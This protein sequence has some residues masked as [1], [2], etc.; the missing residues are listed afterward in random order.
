MDISISYAGESG[1]LGASFISYSQIHFHTFVLLLFLSFSGDRAEGEKGKSWGT[2]RRDRDG[3]AW[4]LDWFR[5]RSRLID[6]LNSSQFVWPFVVHSDNRRTVHLPL[7]RL[8][9]LISHSL[10]KLWDGCCLT[11]FYWHFHIHNFRIF[12]EDGPRGVN[13]DEMRPGLLT[14][15][16]NVPSTTNQ[17]KSHYS[18]HRK[19]WVEFTRLAGSGFSISISSPSLMRFRRNVFRRVSLRKSK[20]SS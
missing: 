15:L 14:K 7:H 10:C 18:T 9:L 13:L 1:E 19:S 6:C 17:I 2:F 5:W 12:R 20:S 8:P 4:R 16:I 3:H 11:Y